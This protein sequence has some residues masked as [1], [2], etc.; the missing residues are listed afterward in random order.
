MIAQTQRN[1]EV[2][3][4]YCH[5]DGY[6][7]HNGRLLNEYWTEQA[8]VAELIEGGDMRS[9]GV[10]LSTCKFYSNGS[11]E[12]SAYV[13]ASR[14]SNYNQFLTMLGDDIEY[15]YVMLR[16]GKWALIDIR[17]GHARSLSDILAE[18]NRSKMHLV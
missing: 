15:V 10:T 13:M 12:D 6:P 17:S 9:L 3:A 2:H 16:T 4:V 18:M 8:D 11:K 7:E 5:S 14:Y 1:G